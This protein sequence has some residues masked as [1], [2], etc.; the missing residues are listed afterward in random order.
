[1]NV[2]GALFIKDN[3]LLLV[4]PRRRS[5][6]QLVAGKVEKGE[7]PLDAMIRESHEE[8]GDEVIFDESLF[9]LVLEFDEIASSDDATPIHYYLYK[10]NGKLSG[11]MTISEEIESFFW[12][13][14][15]CKDIILSNSLNHKIIPYCIEENLI[16]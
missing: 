7:A 4:K 3:E 2:V 14:T 13:D 9:E 5:T 6:Y 16:N 11:N 8:L 12:Y 1:M 15:S 10:Y